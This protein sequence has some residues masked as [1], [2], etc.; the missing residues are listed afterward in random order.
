MTT[1]DAGAIDGDSHPSAPAVGAFLTRSN[2]ELEQP[3]LFPTDELVIPPGLRQLRKAVSAIQAVPLKVEHEHTLN[4]RRL[5]DACILVAQVDMR[6]RS[7][8]EIQ[9]IMD[10]RIS[11]MFEVTAKDLTEKAGIPGKNLQRVYEALDRLFEMVLKWNVVG[12]DAQVEWGMKAHFLSTLGIGQGASAGRIRFSMAP[13]ILKIV[14][15]P[16]IWANLS[17]QTMKQL[18]T[19]SAYALYQTTFRYLGTSQK[20]TA[21]LPLETWIELLVGPSRYVKVDATGKKVINYADFKRRTLL[22]AMERVNSLAA[23]THT[24]ELKEITTGKR[25]S[26]LQFKF[27]P[28]KQESL[29]LPALWPQDMVQVLA[30]IGYSESEIVDL[31]QRYSQE[32]VTDSLVR[33]KA[34]EERRRAAGKRIGSRRAYFEGILTNVDAGAAEDAVAD[35]QLAARAQAIEEARRS[36]ERQARLKEMFASRQASEFQHNLDQLPNEARAVLIAE[37]EAS[38]EGQKTRLL[39]QQKGWERNAPALAVLR[40]WILKTQS[41]ALDLL[42]PLPQ[43]RSFEDWMAWRLEQAANGE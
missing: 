26:K 37:F 31:G 19:P 10:E 35:D 41:D 12:G 5:F 6:R 7:Q 24:L 32:T 20:V 22:D 2:P 9:R 23:L 15:E 17:L 33:L 42:L 3:S 1:S 38:D 40:G 14:L 34:S 25:V 28:K 27:V 8:S 11:P 21:A 43:D 16:S 18:P 29:G 4:T 30:S 39:W 36:T 13:E